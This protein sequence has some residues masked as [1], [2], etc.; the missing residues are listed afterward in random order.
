MYLAAHGQVR[1]RPVDYLLA[2]TSRIF[3]ARPSY[4]NAV[5]A[6]RRC[7]SNLFQKGGANASCAVASLVHKATK[8]HKALG[9]CSCALT[10]LKCYNI[11]C[12]SKGKAVVVV[13]V[14][15]V[16]GQ[17]KDAQ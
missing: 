5:P 8:R 12:C 17:H 4:L 9:P 14:C 10:N 16:K 1:Y 15:R 7:A 2:H 6:S 3:P 11:Q 13:R